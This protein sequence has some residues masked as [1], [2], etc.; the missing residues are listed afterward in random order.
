MTSDGGHAVS[1]TENLSRSRDKQAGVRWPTA[2]DER[3]D[4]LVDAAIDAGE[5]TVRKEVLAALIA[6][7][8]IDGAMLGDLLKRY[9]TMTIDDCLP[10]TAN[11]EGVIE[12]SAHRPGPR[13]RRG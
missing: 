6:T 8:A 9:R 5:R 13:A 3:L 4:Q 12:L 10:S 2:V 1:S 11:A 7:T